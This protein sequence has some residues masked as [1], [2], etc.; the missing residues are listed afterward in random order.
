MFEERPSARV[1][2][3]VLWTVAPDPAAPG[4]PA[5]PVVPD[6]CMDIVWTPG[7]VFV[8]GPDSRARLPDGGPATLHVGLRFAPG[9]AP[10]V[11]G[12][13]ARALLDQRVDL[14]ALWPA[15]GVRDL[16]A[17]LDTYAAHRRHALLEDSV[18]ARDP[19]PEPW[20]RP[21]VAALAAGRPVAATADA[22]G[23]GARTLHRRSLRAFGYGPKTLAR[24]LRL[25]RA[26]ALAWDGTPYGETAYA[27]GYADQAHLAREVR[28]L[29]GLSLGAYL[30]DRAQPSGANS[31][32][33][34]P[35]GSAT[36][37]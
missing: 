21:L 18:L 14:D 4:T 15:R 28:D 30:G 13:P 37:A 9:D 29:T 7:R 31:D 32:T 33:S 1:P 10:D 36:V 35:S 2:G 23:L 27:A 17:R 6:G 8:A 11:L 26:L 5:R 22:L 25:Q 16:T 24:V 19:A 34:P 20:L 12:V 3:A